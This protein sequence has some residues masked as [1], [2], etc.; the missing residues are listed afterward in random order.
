MNRESSPIVNS[1]PTYHSSITKYYFIILLQQITG[2]QM[3]GHLDHYIVNE[4]KN[5]FIC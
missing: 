1:S 4:D 2:E 5:R 3:N